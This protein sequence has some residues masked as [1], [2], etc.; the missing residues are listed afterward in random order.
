MF[1]DQFR[2]T[3]HALTQHIIRDLERFKQRRSAINR[4]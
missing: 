2:D 4:L 1:R 3:L